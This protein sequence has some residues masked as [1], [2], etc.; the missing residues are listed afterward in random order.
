MNNKTFSSSCA[1]SSG[2]SFLPS[3]RM[4][5]NPFTR[6]LVDQALDIILLALSRR[7]SDIKKP[8]GLKARCLF[9]AQN[10]KQHAHDC[11]RDKSTV[12]FKHISS[13]HNQKKTF[14]K[15]VKL[16]SSPIA[17]YVL[18]VKTHRLRHIPR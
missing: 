5:S 3:V 4:C 14:P 17:I 1:K 15:K 6:S 12:C 7:S 2:S 9:G 11:G 16:F 10:A 18:I 13:H 8:F